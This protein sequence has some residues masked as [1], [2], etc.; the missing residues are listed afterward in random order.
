MSRLKDFR[1]PDLR[2]I[3]PDHMTYMVC[4]DGGFPAAN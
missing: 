4:V 3:A 1:L 2:S